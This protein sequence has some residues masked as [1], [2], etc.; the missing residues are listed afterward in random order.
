MSRVR[1]WSLALMVPGCVDGPPE[2]PDPGPWESFVMTVEGPADP[3]PLTCDPLEIP[4]EPDT[5]EA[6]TTW[7]V[8]GARA[9]LYVS[10][11]DGA[12]GADWFD[13]G[14]FYL[15]PAGLELDL[16]PVGCGYD[17]IRIPVD[18]GCREGCTTIR[19]IGGGELLHELETTSTGP[20]TFV[21]RDCQAVDTVRIES[22]EAIVCPLRFEAHRTE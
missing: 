4:I 13:L 17:T 20:H 19:L 12:Y 22:D 2:R 10:S 8:E 11:A 21:V 16:R 7:E 9:S 5:I 6:G 3:G 18:D 15:A 1:L 14:C